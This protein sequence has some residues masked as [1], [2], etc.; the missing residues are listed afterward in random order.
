MIADFC[1]HTKGILSSQEV[2]IIDRE[3]A[4]AIARFRY[5]LIAPI[6]SQLNLASGE[7]AAWIQEAANKQYQIP[8]STKTQVSVRTIE[9][10][11]A[12]YRE[13]G[14]EALV[15][16]Y[17]HTTTAPQRIPQEYLDWAAKLKR[18]VPKRPITQIIAA[19]EAEDKVPKGIL[20]RSTVYEYFVKIGLDRK[21]QT[22]QKKAF[23]RF[24]PKH[25]N[26]RWQGDSC[27]LLYLPDPANSARKKKVYLI[28]WIDE[29]S[30]VLTHAQC[31]FEERRFTL[32]DSLKKAILK[33]GVPSTVYV[34]NGSVYISKHLESACGHLGINISH[35]RPYK[36]QGRGK[37]E[38]VFSTIQTSFLPELEVLQK[39]HHLSL[40]DVNEYL[41]LWITHHYHDR[42]HSSLKQKPWTMFHSDTHPI[43]TADKARLEHAF[44]IEDTRKVDKTGV[45]S[46]DHESYQAPLVLAGRKI[47]IRYNPYDPQRIQVYDGL[48]RF[49]D[50]YPLQT[51]EHVQFND[52][53]SSP[54]EAVTVEC[55]SYLTGL[56]RKA[57]Q[58]DPLAYA[59][60]RGERS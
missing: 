40:G 51:P 12:C 26:E 43:R 48:E 54:E 8:F 25:R 32:E 37:V 13:S 50:A 44:L 45:F 35:T 60:P 21:T 33:H 41:Q 24:T 3:K 46:L 34:D 22:D 31:Y 57:Q 16:K 49:E 18:Q 14:Y 7:Q 15:P 42:V 36:P 19:L 1:E 55:I 59:G 30:R 9:R 58:T 5:S 53:V 6:V 17:L 10:Y 20:K 56:Q 38:R 27:H 23:Q 29:Y 47:T 2:V 52:E 4:Y 11:L 28:A 39:E